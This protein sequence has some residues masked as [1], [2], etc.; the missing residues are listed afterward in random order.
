MTMMYEAERMRN[1][2]FRFVS[3]SK[4]SWKTVCILS[5][6]IRLPKRNVVKGREKKVRQV[7]TMTSVNKKWDRRMTPKRF[8]CVP[9]KLFEEQQF[10]KLFRM[11]VESVEQNRI[12]WKRTLFT[13]CSA[14]DSKSTF[15]GKSS[16]KRNLNVKHF[17]FVIQKFQFECTN[18]W[19]FFQREQRKKYPK[20]KHF[21][22][23][24]N[25]FE[26]T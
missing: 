12:T 20:S 13:L 2:A 18:S 9:L 25:H 6:T 14:F 17:H 8:S 4:R 10:L 15:L 23:Q 26:N 11:I 16:E 5:R 19:K 7:A 22:F 24:I 3:A 1:A 21:Y